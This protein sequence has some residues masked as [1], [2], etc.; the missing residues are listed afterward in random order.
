MSSTRKK[1]VLVLC[2]TDKSISERS[3]AIADIILDNVK[4]GEVA[5]FYV[6]IDPTYC[7]KC[8]I[9]G[10]E[11]LG[12]KCKHFPLFDLIIDEYCPKTIWNKR[13]F[14]VLN[15]LLKKKG[16]LFILKH[17]KQKD[18]TTSRDVKERM[19]SLPSLEGKFQYLHELW[20]ENWWDSLDPTSMYVDEEVIGLI[21]NITETEKKYK[22]LVDDLY[23]I[24]VDILQEDE[25]DD[26]VDLI[27]YF[28]RYFIFKQYR[29]NEDFFELQKR[30]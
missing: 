7:S 11:D 21:K 22:K 23:Q 26:E 6:N 3:S 15:S 1:N 19:Q 5:E 28:Q 8:C 4:K 18:V 17:E 2:A 20:K 10:I 12:K 25:E 14:K 9:S 16:K 24:S 27:V 29:G 13:T 30:S